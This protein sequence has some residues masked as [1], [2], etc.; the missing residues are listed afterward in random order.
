MFV[1]IPGFIQVGGYYQMKERYMNTYPNFTLVQERYN[2]TVNETS[3]CVPSPRPDAFK[4]LK[5]RLRS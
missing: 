4:M 5:V 1:D 2:I 3:D